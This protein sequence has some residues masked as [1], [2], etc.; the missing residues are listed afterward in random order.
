MCTDPQEK[1]GNTF[2]CRRCDECIAT[3]RHGWVARAMAE[4]SM[5]KY[6]LCIALTYSDDSEHSRDA[7]KF[8]Q[9]SDVRDFIKRLA[10]A[11][12]RKDKTARVKFLCAG[13]QG[14]RNGRC[15][16]H[17]I[18]YSD[19]DLTQIGHV[20]LRSGLVTERSKMMTVGKRKR[21]L[22]WS[23]WPYGFVTFQEPDQ[24]GMSYVLSYCLKDQFTHEKT[25]GTMREAK[26]ENFATGLFRMSKRPAIGETFVFAK[27]EALDAKGSVL[28]SLQVKIP[29][30]GGYWHPTSTLREKL[31]WGLR[32]INTRVNWTTGRDAPQWSTLLANSQE[33]PKDMEALIGPQKDE[34]NEVSDETE[35]ARR[36][37]ETAERQRIGQMVR[38]CGG[39]L[40]CTNCLHEIPDAELRRL[41]VERQWP[42]DGSEWT[43]EPLAG[44][45][46]IADRQKRPL[47]QINPYCQRRGSKLAKRAFPK[48]G[49]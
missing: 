13:E 1:D 34:E 23:L 37:R 10:S 44:F 20:Y 4:R 46:P 47:G 31:L 30:F 36:G 29:D 43:Y 12:R 39:L 48:T 14:D 22:N 33:N 41:G 32:A 7:A 38:T 8:F 45:N 49:T 3:R 27:L 5:W 19:L 40:P 21:R 9:Y 24:G 2:A 28:P 25:Y 15:H 35:F 26:T 11:C 16:W 42:S 18:I 17:L 6:A